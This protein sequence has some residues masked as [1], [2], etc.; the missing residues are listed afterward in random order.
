[1]KVL[2]GRGGV[3]LAG[4]KGRALDACTLPRHY[5]AFG[6]LITCVPYAVRVLD[7]T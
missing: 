3:P 6:A 2:G 4:V 7:F 5:L 1:M